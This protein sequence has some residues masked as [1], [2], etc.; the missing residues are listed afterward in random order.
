ML[1]ECV[2]FLLNT[3]F[4]RPV[5]IPNTTTETSETAYRIYPNVL[6]HQLLPTTDTRNA[7]DAHDD[8]ASKRDA[9]SDVSIPFLYSVA[10]HDAPVGNP[11]INPVRIAA[12]EHRGRE[13]SRSVGIKRYIGS[14]KSSPIIIFEIAR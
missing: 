1:S 12:A 6:Q 14:N 2:G 8:I 7:G 5:I 13:K 11:H 10:V 9:S 3:F 4:P